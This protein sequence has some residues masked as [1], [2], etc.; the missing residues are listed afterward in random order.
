MK[1]KLKQTSWTNR[2]IL[3]SL[4]ILILTNPW[5]VGYIGTAVDTAIVYFTLY[6]N[7][8]FVVGLILLALTNIYMM[9]ANRLKTNIPKKS[10]KTTKA[11]KFIEE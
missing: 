5:S 6:A 4:T 8:V 3:L 1:A 2:F 9:Y 10:A 7:Y 11:G